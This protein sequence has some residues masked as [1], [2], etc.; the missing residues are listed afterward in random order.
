MNAVVTQWADNYIAT[1]I[2]AKP[3]VMQLQS[4]Q[5][6]DSIG[7]VTALVNTH[8]I[9]ETAFDQTPEQLVDAPPIGAIMPVVY[10]E[11]IPTIYGC[12]IWEKLEGEDVAAY[13]LFKKYRDM[14]FEKHTRRS[15]FNLAADSGLNMKELELLRQN[16]H[17]SIRAHAFDIFKQQERELIVQL[18]QQ[19][20]EGRHATQ[21]RQLFDKATQYLLKHEDM[22]SPKVAIQ[23]LETAAKLERLASGMGDGRRSSIGTEAPAIN[24]TNNLGDTAIADSTKSIVTPNV[25]QNRERL[26]QVLNI[27][28]SIG[29]LKD[30]EDIVVEAENT[31]S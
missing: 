16:Y 21:A 10:V 25:D 3:Y 1:M 2:K 15:I 17:W 29:A 4:N 20:I 12:P 6:V 19:E 31:E 11:E 30:N 18:R 5:A 7:R 27:M 24:I 14:E 13:E 26:M 9:I 28:N 22:L 23:M 8:V